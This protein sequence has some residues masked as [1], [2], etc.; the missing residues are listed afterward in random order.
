MSSR[1]RDLSRL[2]DLGLF[3]LEKRRLRGDLKNAAKY[4]KDRGHENVVGHFS[5]MAS[6]KIRDNGFQLEHR[7]FQL[8]L[9]RNFFILRVMSTEEA[10]YRG[11]AV[12]F[13]RDLQNSPGHAP[14]QLDLCVPA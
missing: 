13:S 5:V 11:Y 14:L 1:S 3:G 7:R 6:D 12:F 8:K 10:A 2:R 9:R 4:L